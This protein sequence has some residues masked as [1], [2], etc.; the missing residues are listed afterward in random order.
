MQYTQ[1][2]RPVLKVQRL[3]ENGIIPTK[4][5]FFAAGFDLYSANSVIIPPGGKSLVLTDI[6]I[7]LPLGSYGRIAP[8]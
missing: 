3:S 7:Q 8:R 1:H 2:S 6:A 5:S 4:S